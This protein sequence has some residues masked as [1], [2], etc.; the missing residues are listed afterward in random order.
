MHI[1]RNAFEWNCTTT[2]VAGADFNNRGLSAILLSLCFVAVCM[3]PFVTASSGLAWAGAAES[4]FG[5]GSAVAYSPNG[6]IVAS[7]HESSIMIVDTVTNEKIQNFHVDFFVDSIAF[8]SNAQ[9]LLIG[10]VSQLPNTPATIVYELLDGVYE[11][12]MHTEDGENI[13]RISISPDDNTFATASEN[14]EIIEWSINMGTGSI[15]DIDRVYSSPHNGHISCLDHSNDGEHL[16]SGASDGIVILWNRNDQSEITRWEYT[17][18]IVDCKFSNDGTL[19]SWIGDGS[20]YLRNHDVTRSYFGQYDISPN[21]SQM[22]YTYDDSEVAILSSEVITT[23]YRKVDFVE[24]KSTPISTSRTLFIGHKAVMMSLH[25]SS[26]ALAI[27]TLSNLV[28]FYSDSVYSELLIPSS[29]DTDQDNLADQVDDDDDGDGIIDMY[30]NICIAGTNCHLQPDQNFIRQ[31]DITINQDSVIVIETIHLDAKNSHQ[32]RI[33][34]SNSLNSNHRVDNDEFMQIQ[35]SICTEYNVDEVLSRWGA[36][37]EIDDNPYNPVSVQCSIEKSDLYGTM[38]SDRGTRI[39]VS[40]QVQGFIDAPVQTPY[41]VSI[42]SGIQ[43]PSESIA[44]NVH[45]FPIHVQ[46]EDVS[47][48]RIDYE[49]WNRRDPDIYLLMDIPPI[50]EKSNVDSLVELLTTYW[51]AFAFISLLSISAISL[52]IMRHR[53]TID[54]TDTEEPG[55]IDSQH[56]EELEQL[57]D[58][59]A[60]WDEEMEGELSPKSGPVPPSAVIRDLRGMPMPPGAVQRDIAR[61][62]R[63]PNIPSSKKQKVK[64]TRKTESADASGNESVDFK[65]LIAPSEENKMSDIEDEETISDAIAYITSETGTKPKKKRPVRRKK[66]SN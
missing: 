9:Y 52:A 23:Q 25:P 12:T 59:A 34:A 3:T 7:A 48:S 6:D 32:L 17:H 65:H 31:F 28:A 16:L 40:W 43:T 41:N 53:N 37:L 62:K 61:Q 2:I 21:A 15:L 18:P 27:S 66:S 14:G 26:N 36:Y 56:D 35:H 50:D 46:I 30:D 13:D 49:V 24:I 45:A 11:R 19:M 39:S 22:L 4:D 51:Y 38:D 44:Q 5:Y 33:L 42:L 58:D 20:L 64:R 1:L 55:Y 60:A 47:G 63:Q 10:M 29:I 54:F 57:I 8:T